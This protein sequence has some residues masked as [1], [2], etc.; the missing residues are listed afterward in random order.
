[1]RLPGVAARPLPDLLGTGIIDKDVFSA[2]HAIMATRY[3]R[4]GV[5]A[6]LP[7]CSSTVAG[8]NPPP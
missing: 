8:V 2:G 4:L 3:E 5:R 7:P 1:M 6:L